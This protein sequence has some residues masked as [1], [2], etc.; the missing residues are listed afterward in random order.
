MIVELGVKI[1]V[2]VVVFAMYVLLGLCCTKLFKVKS[3]IVVS[4]SLW[5]FSNI[6]PQQVCE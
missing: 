5:I 3:Y 2:L 4:N 6:L 1:K